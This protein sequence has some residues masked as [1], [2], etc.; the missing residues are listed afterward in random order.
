M[1]QIF[2]NNAEGA[3]ASSITNSQTSV[4]LADASSFP[5]PGSD[6]YLATFVGVDNNG[7]E[8]SWEIVRVTAK[9]TNTLTITRAQEGTTAQAWNAST[10]FQARIT[11]GSLSPPDNVAI[12]GGSVDGVSIGATTPVSEVTSNGPVSGSTLSGTLQWSDVANEPTTLAGYGI[13]DAYTEAEVDAL[14]WDFATD[15][16]GKPTTVSGYGIT[17]AVTTAGNQTVGG[18]K[19]FTDNVTAPEFFGDLNGAVRFSAQAD[20]AITK[21]QAVYI[22][23]VS[24]NTVTVALADADNASKMPAFGLAAA[25]VSASSAVEIVTFGTLSSLDTSSFSVGNNLFVSTTPGVLTSTPPT[26]ESAQIQNVGKVKRSN[27]TVGSIKVGGAGRSATTPNLNDGNIFLGNASNQAVTTSLDTAVS[28]AGYIKD[29][30]LSLG[31]TTATDQPINIDQGTDITLVPATT[32]LAGL[33]SAADKTKLDGVESGATADQTGAEIKSLYEAEADTNAYTDA[34]QTKVGHLTVTQAVDLDAIET[35]VNEL[36]ASVILMG[37]WDASSG[38]FPGGGTAQAGESWIVSVSG[39]VD[40]VSF[41]ANDRIIAITDNASTT[42]YANNWFKADYTDLVQSVVGQTGAVTAGQIETAVNHDNLTGFVAN[43]HVDHSAITISGGVGLSGSGDIT[44]NVTIDM[45]VNGLTGVTNLTNTDAFPIWDAGANGHRKITWSNLKSEI[46]TEVN[47]DNLLGFVANEHIDWTTD[48]GATDINAANIS[49]ASVTQ[50]Q[51]ALSIT[52]SQISDL[53]HAVDVVSNV[54]TSTILGR[55]TAGSGDSEELTPASV[56]T[57]LNVED[58]ATADQTDAEIRAAVEAATDSNVFTD[59]DHSKLNGIEAGATADQ[60][61]AEIRAAVEAA[62]DSNVFTDADHSKLNGISANANNYSHP[63]HTGEVT[64]SSDGATT[65]TVSA[66]TNRTALTTGIVDA[67]ELLINDSG[68][69]KRTDVSVLGGYMQAS[70]DHDSFQGFVANEHIDWTTDQGATDINAGNISESSVT[71]HQAALLDSLNVLEIDSV[72]KTAGF[73]VTSGTQY[74]VDTSG[75]AFTVTL[76]L[77]PTVGDTFGIIDLTGTFGT[78]AVTLARNGSN[79]LRAAEDGLIDINNWST[80]WIYTGTTNG[81]LPVGAAAVAGTS[82]TTGS[83]F[84]VQASVQTSAFTAV[85]GELYKL[86][87]TSAGFNVTLPASPTEGDE[88]FFRFVNGSDPSANNV[89][90]LRNGSEI[91]NETTDLIWDVASPKYFSLL[92]LTEDGWTTRL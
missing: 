48:Q 24:G 21:G 29:A 47:H 81:W 36:D 85:A 82:G 68:A 78:N 3:T 61:D 31:T 28:T 76:P 12:T 54:A 42:T 70:L 40:S 38:S 9:V 84:T 89:T 56:R 67:D 14:T 20:E 79:V 4:V 23:G 44:G 83:G 35:R 51:A 69:L 80:P 63:D 2:V 53:A 27:A 37:T 5:D 34:E 25:S 22:T 33:M 41:T 77:S 6:Y 58:G 39:T 17:D 7:Q 19:T 62:T 57:L 86:D 65:L 60:T 64:S 1:G 87:C 88:V 45:D 91:E 71:Q 11:G 13:T 92:Y 59:A 46:E 74:L 18:E 73:T 10:P 26:G 32:S 66:I 43:E 50:H 75:G 49:E 15:I 72:A 30:N 55:A 52:E 90:F 8:N 16:T